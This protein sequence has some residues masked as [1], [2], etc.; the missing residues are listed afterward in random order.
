MGLMNLEL[1]K[2]AGAATLSMIDLNP[3]KLETAKLLG[4]S[5]A[6]TNADELDRLRGWD[7]VIDCTGV[8]AAIEDAIRRV[9]KGGTFRQFGVTDH[10]AQVKV[11]PSLSALHTVSLQSRQRPQ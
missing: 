7:V 3:T 5:A 2:R 6:V 10:G 9:G 1:A 11:D 8:V 4:C